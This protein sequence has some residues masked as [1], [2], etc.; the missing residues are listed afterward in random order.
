MKGRSQQ[1]RVPFIST[2]SANQEQQ[3]GSADQLWYTGW[4]KSAVCVRVTIM[5]LKTGLMWNIFSLGKHTRV[6]VGGVSL[7]YLKRLCMCLT[8]PRPPPLNHRGGNTP[9]VSQTSHPALTRW[10][11]ACKG[12][13]GLIN[14]RA[15]S[16]PRHP[17]R[18]LQHSVWVLECQTW[19]WSRG[20][21]SRS[22]DQIYLK[23]LW[24]AELGRCLEC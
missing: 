9:A 21:G 12:W 19:T 15:L 13:P 18:V 2:A 20:K 5:N 8:H 16:D 6:E 4:L 23:G 14:T 1:D 22:A 17:G 10:T 3:S 7:M 11:W 24:T